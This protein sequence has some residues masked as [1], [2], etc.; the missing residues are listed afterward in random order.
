MN[1]VVYFEEAGDYSS[2]CGASID[3]EELMD[4][5]NDTDRITYL[6]VYG[7]CILSFQMYIAHTWISQGTVL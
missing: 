1:I 2:T 6:K 5:E 3:L 7:I 4:L